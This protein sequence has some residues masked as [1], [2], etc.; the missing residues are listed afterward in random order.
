[1]TRRGLS[2]LLGSICAAALSLGAL[3]SCDEIVGVDWSA[4]EEKQV[5]LAP[6]CDG[7]CVT[8]G[9]TFDGEGDV[10]LRGF[11]AAS[12]GGLLLWGGAAGASAGLGLEGAGEFVA[13]TCAAGE[14]RWSITYPASAGVLLH[15]VV[16][17]AAGGAWIAGRFSGTLAFGAPPSE[18]ATADGMAGFLE[19][20]GSDGT[21]DRRAFLPAP[22]LA[23]AF[24][25]KATSAPLAAVIGSKANQ[26]LF[27]S[28]PCGGSAENVPT[29]LHVL[30]LD[31][32]GACLVREACSAVATEADDTPVALQFDSSGRLVFVAPFDATNGDLHTC[33]EKD[34]KAAGAGTHGM[35]VARASGADSKFETGFGVARIPN[36]SPAGPLFLAIDPASGQH[37]V[38]GTTK[39]TFKFSGVDVPANG[40]ASMFLL[41]FVDAGNPQ[42][43]VYVNGSGTT[44]SSRAG[45]IAF[46][47]SG[48]LSFVSSISGSVAWQTGTLN[49]DSED[50]IVVT[51][52]EVGAPLKFSVRMD[53]R[54]SRAPLPFV[55]S[56]PGC[57]PVL[58]TSFAGGI[59]AASGD[60]MASGRDVAIVPGVDTLLFP[61]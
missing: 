14:L 25:P 49:A 40:R 18:P 54:S 27:A 36:Y 60:L 32:A 51:D 46:G 8:T 19:H 53:T 31:A 24:D 28:G 1:M 57:S 47:P 37:W 38:S 39:E 20:V 58:G 22:A 29:G 41:Q 59:G 30:R 10:D 56:P 26:A 17:D 3:A 48:H 15:A 2:R 11:V 44:G 6:P 16:S 35:V 23:L 12:D 55:A 42:E 50:R 45:S 7:S 61:L 4:Y 9:R 33:S 43:A 13:K 34:R 21:P 5:T 52:V